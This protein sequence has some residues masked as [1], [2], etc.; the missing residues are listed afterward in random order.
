MSLE[1]AFTTAATDT[2]Y[3]KPVEKQRHKRLPPFSIRLSPDE[4]ARLAMEAAGAPL[5]RVVVF[6]EKEGR[7][8]AHCAWSRID[9]ETMKARPLPFFKRKLMGV[10]RDLYLEN[11]WKMPRGLEN[12]RERNPTNFSLA[13]WQQAKRQS[14]D[15]RWLKQV[16]QDCWKRSDNLHAFKHSLSEH[17]F[18]LAAGTKRAT[19][20]TAMSAMDDRKSGA[21]VDANNKTKA[22][23]DKDKKQGF[24]IVDHNGEVFSVSRMLDLKRKEV[25]ERLGSE[26]D[27][28][29]V[30]NTKKHVGK[31]MSGALKR[32]IAESRAQFG[33]RS[34]K[35]GQYKEEMTRLHRDAR[36]KL[37]DRHKTEWDE[38]TKLRAA[39][40]PRGLLGIWHRLTGKYQEVRSQNETEA[41]ATR[42][43]QAE[44]HQK[45]VEKQLDQ[46][47]VL[48]KQF[49]DLRKQQAEQLLELR[50]D[51]GRYLAF[52][53]SDH[54][55]SIGRDVSVGLKLER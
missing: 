42:A 17:G 14:V 34:A 19:K 28:E 23:T 18:F 1:G 21:S 22:A 45:L 12:A 10:S 8:H 29:T 48:Q 52:T 24:V 33:Q 46:R 44:E 6:H 53:R 36:I 20:T 50:S 32:H 55:Q 51:I 38:E 26:A 27:L 40:L 31:N 9:A 49:K 37:D 54:G 5:A 13:E 4:R 2:A 41:Q 15:P 35:L 43:R 11:G 25:R 16:I 39:R 7:R 3:P 47:T 30:E